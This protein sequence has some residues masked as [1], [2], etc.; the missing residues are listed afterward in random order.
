MIGLNVS[1]F[2]AKNKY[3]AEFTKTLK[4]FYLIIQ[5]LYFVTLEQKR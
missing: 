3:A 2:A 5:N 4:K 1:N